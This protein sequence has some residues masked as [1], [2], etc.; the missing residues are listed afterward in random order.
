MPRKRLGL[1]LASGF[2]GYPPQSDN[3][4]VRQ[5]LFLRGRECHNCELGW[6][7]PMFTGPKP[8][9]SGIGV[10]SLIRRQGCQSARQKLRLAGAGGGLVRLSVLPARVLVETVVQALKLVEVWI[11]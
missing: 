10:A 11:K 2:T 3:L 6:A 9:P 7:A 4:A 1:D 5:P 8:A